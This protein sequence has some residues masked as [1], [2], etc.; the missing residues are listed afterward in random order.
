MSEDQG[1]DMKSDVDELT[2]K[3]IAEADKLSEVKTDEIEQ[4]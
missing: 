3:M 1:K 4:L 2:K